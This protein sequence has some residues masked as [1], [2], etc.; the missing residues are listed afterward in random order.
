MIFYGSASFVSGV[1]PYRIRIDFPFEA[2]IPF[3]PQVAIVYLSTLL[4]LL[5]APFVLRRFEDLYPFF[6]VLCIETIVGAVIFIVLP[7]E[8]GY[9]PRAASGSLPGLFLLADTLNLERNELPALHVA[10][11]FTAA[12][13]Y[14]PKCGRLAG[15]AMW[16]WAAAIA[17]STLFMHEHHLLDVAAGILLAGVIM[18]KVRAWAQRPAFTDRAE[19]ELL[20]LR[21]FARFSRRHLRYAAIAFAIYR[22]GI[23]RFRERRILRTGF[24]LL[25]SVDDLLDGDRPSEREPLQV[26]EKLVAEIESRQFSD[27]TLSRLA[28]AF[29]SDAKGTCTGKQDAVADAVA[30]IRHMRLDRQ[31]ILQG[32]VLTG[33]QL[34]EHHRRTFHLSVNLMLVAAGSP[35]RAADVPALID[36]FGWCS[37]MRDLDEDLANGLVNIPREVIERARTAGVTELSFAAL[38]SSAS[39][40]GWMKA[41][42]ARA[43][44]QLDS[45]D[46][47]LDALGNVEGTKTLRL[48]ARSIRRSVR[49]YS[50]ALPGQ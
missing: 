36:A 10:F 38:S 24:C 28:A 50:R 49:R 8:P 3:V 23:G 29:V 34:R 39:V 9:P 46:V 20:C 41:E 4:I 11:A 22:A 47:Q 33:Q 42:L 18:Q 7:V 17:L 35:V 37:T 12:A 26:V 6:I 5:C 19:I 27:S 30:L 32:T 43:R 1:V 25:Q 13:A 44:K 2:Q 48:F 21:E 31:R 16:C 45:A 14:Q 15:I 40:R